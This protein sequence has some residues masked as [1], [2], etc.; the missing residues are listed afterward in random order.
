MAKNLFK[1]FVLMVVIM[2]LT[3]GGSTQVK[4]LRVKGAV[5]SHVLSSGIFSL[6]QNAQSVDWAVLNN[7]PAS[8]TIRVTV[9]KCVTGGTPKT[10]VAPGPLTKNLK[11]YTSTHNANSV[12]TVFTRGFYYEL[13]VETN[14]LRVL[15]SVHVWQDHTNTVIPGTLIPAGSFVDVK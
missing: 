10:S 7:S 2:G 3:V 8:Q 15:P 9:Y 12:G 4:K 13:V 1:I 6:P 5:Y 14:D 11:P